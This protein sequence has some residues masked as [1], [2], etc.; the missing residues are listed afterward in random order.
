M[1]V[2]VDPLIIGIIVVVV[3]IAGLVA[4]GIT[5]HGGEDDL[6]D[7]VEVVDD[8]ELTD[9]ETEIVDGEEEASA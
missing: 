6:S 1:E 7:D 5:V 8:P 9:P 2:I 4:L 3:I